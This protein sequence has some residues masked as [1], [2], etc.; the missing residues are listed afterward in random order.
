MVRQ[1]PR[2]T[3]QEDL[4]IEAAHYTAHYRNLGQNVKVYTQL[5]VSYLNSS[6][7][8]TTTRVVVIP[9]GSVRVSYSEY[10]MKTKPPITGLIHPT[11][12]VIVDDKKALT[13]YRIPWN[14]HNQITFIIPHQ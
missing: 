8:E 13:N 6:I 10:G 4:S 1:S 7:V 9:L 3:I 5:Y 12:L 11:N 2:L 14:F